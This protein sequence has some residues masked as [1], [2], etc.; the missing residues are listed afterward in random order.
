[1]LAAAV[2][3]APVSISTQAKPEAAAT[4]SV[5]ISFVPPSEDGGSAVTGYELEIKNAE[6]NFVKLNSPSC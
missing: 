2:P 6:G 1:M 5:V 4:E 3:N